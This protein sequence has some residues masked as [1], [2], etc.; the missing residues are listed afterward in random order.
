MRGSTRGA[1]TIA[2]PVSRPNASLP[3]S[4]ITKLRL[5]LTTC[6]NGCAG[7]SPI[8][9][10]SGR[11][12]ARRG[13]CAISAAQPLRRELGP[14]D[15]P[16]ARRRQRRQH[17]LV[18]DPVLPRDQRP[19]LVA[20]PRDEVARLGKR[21]ARRRDLRAELLLDARD[22]DLEE[23]VQVAA[24]DAQEAQPLEQRHL[25]VLGQREHA[26]VEVE[27][28]ELA[29]D[30]RG[31]GRGHDVGRGRRD[32]AAGFAE[33]P[34][35]GGRHSA[36]TFGRGVRDYLRARAASPGTARRA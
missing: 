12:S 16:H 33:T 10:S 36:G 7:S 5:L 18:Q 21:D 8:G 29:V 28:R 13:S 23:L 34:H 24:D 27:Q 11:T 17:L 25:G 2:M 19:R 35:G 22:A 14:A 31:D 4:S 15:E 32:P 9:V 3:D 1:F 20:H 30:G 26:P 6:G